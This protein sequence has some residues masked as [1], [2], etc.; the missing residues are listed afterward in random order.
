[1]SDKELDEM[2]NIVITGDINLRDG[3]EAERMLRGLHGQSATQQ[4]APPPQ[5]P[6][7]PQQTQ[8]FQPVTIPESSNRFR[9]AAL[10]TALVLGSGGFG[11]FA[12]N[13]LQ[14]DNTS[15]PE[16]VPSGD[17]VRYDVEKW[18]PPAQQ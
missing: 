15:K 14:Q 12:Y 11:A 1:M 6:P 18:T 8:H 7:Q 16:V 4:S 13:R 9:D 5:P 10:I 17:G 3:A 2:G